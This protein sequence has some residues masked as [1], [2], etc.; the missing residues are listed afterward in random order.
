MV[1]HT[2]PPDKRKTT[3]IGARYTQHEAAGIDILRGNLDRGTWIAGL[4]R[5]ELD[6]AKADGRL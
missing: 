3:V 4:V 5:R 6:K 2:K 1:A